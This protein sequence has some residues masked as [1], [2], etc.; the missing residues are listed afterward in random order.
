MVAQSA[1][2]TAK[3]SVGNNVANIATAIKYIG[4]ISYTGIISTF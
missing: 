3:Q 2:T 4:I 1:K